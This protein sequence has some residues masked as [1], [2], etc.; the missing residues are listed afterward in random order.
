[1]SQPTFNQRWWRG[2]DCYRPPDEPI[3]TAE[4]EVAELPDDTQ[5]KAFVLDH[6]YSG[7]YPAARWRF[8]LFHH[9]R[10]SGVAVFSHP[11]NDRVFTNVFAGRPTDAVELGRFV[12]LDAVPGNGE[13]WMLG[14]CFRA[15]R[16]EAGRCDCL[17]RPVPAG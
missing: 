3:R 15:L 10:L 7:S 9:G 4:Y 16:R 5:A 17:L 11:C 2:R 1:M 13:T 14:Q 6:H 8:G 12:L